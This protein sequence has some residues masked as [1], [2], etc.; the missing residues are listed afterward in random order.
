[1]MKPRISPF[2]GETSIFSGA[3]A[4]KHIYATRKRR[5]RAIAT[6]R[7]RVERVFGALAR[8]GGK[9]LRCPGTVRTTFVL[10]LKAASYKLKRFVFLQVVWPKVP[11]ALNITLL[12]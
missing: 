5:K 3:H 2:A 12:S 8:M 1:M 4:T 6:P 7:I 10:Q 11:D 9:L